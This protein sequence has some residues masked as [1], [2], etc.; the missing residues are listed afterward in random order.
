[1]EIKWT[2][3]VRN[4]EV[5]LGVKGERNVLPAIQRRNV[6]WIGHILHRNCLLKQAIERKVDRRVVVTGRR[7]GRRKQLLDNQGNKRMP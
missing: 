5:L 4:G 2:D 1:V 3:P 7:E 6:K